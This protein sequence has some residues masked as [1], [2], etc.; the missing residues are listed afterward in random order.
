MVARYLSIAAAAFFLN[1][2]IDEITVKYF[3]EYVKEKMANSDFVL[4]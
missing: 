2:G 3:D 1:R 4:E